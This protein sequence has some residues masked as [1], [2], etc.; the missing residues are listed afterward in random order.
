MKKAYSKKEREAI[1][2]YKIMGIVSLS[3]VIIIGA[4]LALFNEPNTSGN[5]QYTA[6]QLIH[7]HNGD[8]IPEH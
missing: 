6:E 8:G 2:M 7:D 5:G 4:W 3:I 1:R